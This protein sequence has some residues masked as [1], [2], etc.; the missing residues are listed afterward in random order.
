MRMSFQITDKGSFQRFNCVHQ[1]MRVRV[2]CQTSDVPAENVGYIF[3]KRGH[4][5]DRFL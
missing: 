4:D 1:A 2:P 3:M 5:A